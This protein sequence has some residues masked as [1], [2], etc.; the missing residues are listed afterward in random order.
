[1]QPVEAGCNSSTQVSSHMTE[2]SDGFTDGQ[3][4]I[5]CL[6][7]DAQYHFLGAPDRLLQEEKLALNIAARAYL[8]RLSV[9]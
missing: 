7:V 1:M 5:N 3:T 2:T 4:T 6:K 8:K 9:I